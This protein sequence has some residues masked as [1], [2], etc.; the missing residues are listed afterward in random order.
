[1]VKD[2][3]YPP[4]PDRGTVPAESIIGYALLAADK[5]PMNESQKS[6]LA[7]IIGETI[8]TTDA[9]RAA[10]RYCEGR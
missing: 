1:M 3:F 4:R 7:F 10:R 8:E 9:E 5:L 2:K 6:A